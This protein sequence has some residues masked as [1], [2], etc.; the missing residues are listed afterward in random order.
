MCHAEELLQVVARRSDGGL[1]VVDGQHR[2]AAAILRRDIGQL[3][4]VISSYASA[5]DE[6]ASPR[7]TD[8]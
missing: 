6:A 7:G 1:Y 5:G 2:M 3:P 8:D 4:C